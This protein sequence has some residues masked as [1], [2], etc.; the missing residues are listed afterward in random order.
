MSSIISGIGHFLQA[1][2]EVIQGAISGVVGIL[3]AAVNSVVWVIRE[4]IQLILGLVSNIAGLLEGVIAFIL[5][6]SR[7][8]WTRFVL[9]QS[10]QY[11]HYWCPRGGCVCLPCVPG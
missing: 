1:I 6:R 4:T 5:S 7:R 9:I 10:R 2:L 11:P 3:Q 8:I